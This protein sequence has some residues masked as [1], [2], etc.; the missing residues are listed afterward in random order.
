MYKVGSLFA[1]I[2]G[3]ELAATWAGFT[4]VWSNEIDPFCCKVLRKNFSHEIIEEDIR[5]LNGATLEPID[6]LTGGFPCQPFSQAGK[7]KGTKDNRY[8]WPEMLRIIREVRPR[9]IVG[10][11]VFGIT[12]WEGG[13][14]FEQVQTEMEAQGY[15]V[16]TFIL[17]ACAVGAP[18]RRDRIWF[19]AYSDGKR[20]NERISNREER[21]ILHDEGITKKNQSERQGRKCGFGEIGKTS[22]YNNGTRRGKLI[23][24]EISN[25]SR[26]YSGNTVIKW[27][28][29]PTESPVCIGNDGVS[30]RLVRSAIKGAGNAIV[31]QVA[32]QI[33]NAIKEYDIS[34]GSSNR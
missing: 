30:S 11:N 25:K 19:V 10:E 18:H 20:W 14:V 22:S 9:W 4:P 1:G 12:N 2:G 32:L 5:K 21:Q 31:P 16:Q 23:P 26:L 24:S 27:N 6:I 3:F 8:L 7:R 34:A 15:E 29:W 17:P 28:H 33:F 13:L